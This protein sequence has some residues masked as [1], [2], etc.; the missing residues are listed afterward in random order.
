MTKSRMVASRLR[1]NDWI[2]RRDGRACRVHTVI[3]FPSGA[4]AIVW[5]IDPD[6]GYLCRYD[7]T[8][9]KK[10]DKADIRGKGNKR[11]AAKTRN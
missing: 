8:P 9:D 10:F 11:A 6:N 2:I 4:R 5:Y 7:C 3:I 1:R